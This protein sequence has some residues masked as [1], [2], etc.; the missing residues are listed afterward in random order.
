MVK[1]TSKSLANPLGEHTL[2]AA[3]RAGDVE[4]LVV[5]SKEVDKTLLDPVASILRAIKVLIN[6]I[7]ERVSDR[8]L[9]RWLKSSADRLETDGESL[10]A[11]LVR[12]DT[13]AECLLGLPD[14][15]NLLA[16]GGVKAN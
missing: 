2:S 11:E 4:E 3:R 10:V 9:G 12:P 7:V 8:G 1:G 13:V 14:L 16:K 5:A 6:F 15:I